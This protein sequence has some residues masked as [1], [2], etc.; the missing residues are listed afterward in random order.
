MSIPKNFTPVSQGIING[1]R[2]P[3][4]TLKGLKGPD[5]KRH[6]IHCQLSIGPKR[7]GKIEKKI[8]IKYLS[9]FKILLSLSGSKR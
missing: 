1:S 8:K 4:R 3:K 6:R 7:N 2:G 5:R 9:W